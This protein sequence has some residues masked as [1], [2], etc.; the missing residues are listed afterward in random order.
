VPS[1]PRAVASANVPLESATFY[2]IPR[3][4]PLYNEH[5]SLLATLVKAEALE[6][7]EMG[8]WHMTKVSH[9]VLPISDVQ[10]SRDWYV[11]KLGFTFDGRDRGEGV[12]GI[13]D[14]SGLTI[15]LQKTS[16]NLAAQKITLTIQVGNVDKKF[17]ELEKVGVKFVSPPKLQFW[18]YGAE[19]LDPDGYM[20]H[21]W[22]EV[23]MNEATRK[24]E[25]RYR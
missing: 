22:D 4:R 7:R 25:K 12:A 2:N 8:T 11:E 10:K 6:D 3:L 18:G 15:F 16:G 1:D 13:E 20:N 21:L 19:V 9:I 5:R 17:Q 14:Q 23:T 24:M